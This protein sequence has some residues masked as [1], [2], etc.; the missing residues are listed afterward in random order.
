MNWQEPARPRSAL[1]PLSSLSKVPP[2][3]LRAS[4]IAGV[5]LVAVLGALFAFNAF[6]ANS[7]R[8]ALTAN[9]RPPTA[10][11]MEAVQLAPMSK[12]ITAVGSLTAVHQVT[13]SSEVAGQ[14]T[15]IGFEGGA[16]VKKGD[17]LVQLNDSGERADLASFQA[18]QRVSE[19]ALQRGTELQKRGNMA[20]AQL[21]QLRSQHEVARAAVERTR[22]LIA[23]KQIRAPFDGMLGVREVEV[24][25]YLAPG[26]AI[27]SLTDLSNLYVNLSVPEQ[28]RPKLSAGQPVRLTVDAH[29]DRIFQAE[30]AVIDPQINADSRTVRVQATVPNEDQALS[31][32]MYAKASVILP[33]VPDV[34]SLP[35]TAVGNSLYGDFVFMVVEDTPPDGKPRLVSKRTPIT[36][37]EHFDGRVAVLTGLKAGDRVVTVGLTK[38]VDGGEV[39][40]SSEASTVKPAAPPAR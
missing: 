1:P 32:G 28:D 11:T 4:I 3:T 29:E 20:D 21:D 35:E 22:T 18:Q 30:I 34:L 5:V 39:V 7:Q 40:P 14:I 16:T 36:A 31:P 25:Q 17:V 13:V 37:G 24:G 26:Q 33:P 2:R 38:V 23:K 27:T 19:L 6:R 15:N 10:V 8:A 12:T 9:K